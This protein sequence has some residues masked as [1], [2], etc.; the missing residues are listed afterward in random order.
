M[1]RLLS[2]A[3]LAAVAVL[4]LAPSL[5]L[6]TLPSNNSPQNI[7]WARQ[8]AGQFGAGNLYPRWMP[9]S[10]DG[11]G[12]PTFYFYPPLP[13]WLDGLLDVAT[14]H[15]LPVEYRL[16]IVFALLLWLSG[17]S[18]H[19]FLRDLP[20]SR[21]AATLGA[22]AYMAAP[23]H[24]FDHYIRGVLAEFAAYTMLP[25]VALGI[26]WAAT[27]HRFGIPLLAAAYGGLILCHL[28]TALLVSIT[29]VP[30]YALYHRRAALVPCALG[31]AWGVALGAAYLV[32]A[33]RLQPFISA[34]QLWAPAYQP[35]NWLLLVAPTT[36]QPHADFMVVI[37]SIAG[38][39]ALAAAGVLLLA[40]RG[41]AALWSALALACLA[42][43]AGLVPY[44]WQ[45]V[46][47]VAKVQFPWRLLVVVEF[48]AIA[49]LCLAPWRAST[50]P[51]RLVLAGAF[52]ALFPAISYT[53][54]GTAGRVH[55]QLQG[56]PPRPSDVKEYLPAG[57][58][59]K[60]GTDFEELGLEPVRDAP[61]IA[62][63]PAAEVCEATE[64]RFG[65][66]AIRVKSAQPVVVTVRRFFFPSWQ[67]E[68]ATP[69]SATDPYRLLSFTSRAG[70]H[71]YRLQQR[72]VPEE[73]AG[74]AVSLLALLALLGVWLSRL[75]R[76]ARR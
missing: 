31:L 6:G 57:F 15:L 50:L 30:A 7:D 33:L 14:G 52:I 55:L 48:A 76:P 66:L 11:L 3:G 18:M 8:F 61:L 29:M 71:L 59:Q 51:I 4:L 21:L 72:A 49:A 5:L 62:C 19:A 54:V 10:F 38:G 28:P 45:V 41:E 69:L 12:S 70:D 42:L 46:P 39:C 65:A 40:R 2:L 68:P 60:A 26:R 73:I 9:L 63:A 43:I 20:I 1:P 58:P 34:E 64:Q 67:L 25:L 35:Q 32:P 27:R 47:L 75:L 53:A 36:F 17:V 37:K 13:Y 74:D 16:S 56:A 44:F 22:V 23:Y 24:L